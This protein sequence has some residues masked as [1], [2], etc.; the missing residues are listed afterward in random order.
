MTLRVLVFG[1][2]GQLAA[3]LAT[4]KQ[5]RLE[6][7]FLGRRDA[8]LTD[9]EACAREVTLR[10]GDAVVIAAA[11]TAVDQAEQE[12]DIAL[13]VN[14][15]APEA[16]AGAARRRGIPVIH[17]S[18]D[19]VFDGESDQP[20]R[21]ADP[22]RPLNAYGRS[23]LEGE[24]RV[25]QTGARGAILRTSWV[26]GPS[27]KNFVQTMLNAGR[28]CDE[29]RVVGDQ[30]GGPTPASALAHAVLQLASACAETRRPMDV[31]HFQGAPSAS[32]AEFAERIFLEHASH[33]HRRPKIV[34]IPT[35]EYPTPARRPRRTVLDCSR[36]RE[37]HAILQPDWRADLAQIIPKWTAA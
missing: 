14:A 10:G 12:E 27:G 26:F 4:L 7:E 35:S 8:E 24:Y 20:Y 36:I 3:A 28:R 30:F 16:I 34:P 18:S 15:R 37:A 19:Y 31:F 13:C 23:K 29:L 33:G 17:L 9:P 2:T 32:W 5:P 6:L 21:E 25:L 22:P 1:K 11:Y